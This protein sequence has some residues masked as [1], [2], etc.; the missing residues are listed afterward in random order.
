M[1]K[2]SD[3]DWA[4]VKKGEEEIGYAWVRPDIGWEPPAAGESATEPLAAGGKLRLDEGTLTLEQVNALLKALPVDISFVDEG[5]KVAYYSATE[6]RIFPRSPGV[7]G[8]DVKNCHPPKSVH[9]VQRILDSFKA[10][11]KDVAEFWLELGGRFLHIR[12][13]PVRS[14]DGRFLGTLEV[15]QDVTAIRKLSGQKRLLDWE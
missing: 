2:F 15:T 13:F 12:Y 8:R 14:M 7:I 10:G 5:G 9:V 4:R 1:E 11:R 6:D 3:A